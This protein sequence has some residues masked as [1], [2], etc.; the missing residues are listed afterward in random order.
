MTK[1]NVCVLIKSLD[2]GEC[3]LSVFSNQ[4][5]VRKIADDQRYIVHKKQIVTAVIFKL[6][7]LQRMKNI[8][9]RDLFETV[10]KIYDG[11]FCEKSEWLTAFFQ[12]PIKVLYTS[13]L[14]IQYLILQY[15]WHQSN[16]SLRDPSQLLSLAAKVTNYGFK[17]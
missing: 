10:S 12:P 17:A 3:L 6:F 15:R 16:S 2:Q 1:R 11:A 13:E 5:T 8:S 4:S 9:Q 14:Q 7:Y